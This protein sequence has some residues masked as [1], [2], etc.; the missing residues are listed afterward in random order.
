MHAQCALHMISRDRDHSEGQGVGRG[1]QLSFG[2]FLEIHPF[3]YFHPP[4]S[5]ISLDD[6]YSENIWFHGLNLHIIWPSYLLA[7]MQPYPL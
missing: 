7:Y 4:L 5:M 2:T 3:W 6:I 1:G